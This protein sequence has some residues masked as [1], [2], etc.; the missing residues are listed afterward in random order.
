MV[1]ACGRRL[2]V[3]VGLLA[4]LT[5]VGCGLVGWQGWHPPH[6]EYARAL[7]AIESTLSQHWSVLPKGSQEAVADTYRR[8]GLLPPGQR[9]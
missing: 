2:L 3:L 7:G 5:V 8:M 1:L 4:M 9:Q 6:L